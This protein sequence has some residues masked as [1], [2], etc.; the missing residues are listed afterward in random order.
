MPL[1]AILHLGKIWLGVG[2]S[3]L[4]KIFLQIQL[5]PFRIQIY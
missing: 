1:W 4:F 5:V 2:G 3:D